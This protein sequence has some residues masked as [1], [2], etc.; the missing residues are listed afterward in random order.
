MELVSNTFAFPWEVDLMVWLQ[1]RLP[2]SLISLFSKLSFFGEEI[3]LIAVLGFL[4]WSYDKRSA[5]RIGAVLVMVN[6]WSPMIKNVI[7]RRRPYMAHEK[8]SIKR[9]VAADADLNDI[10]AQGYSFP[11]QHSANISG[12]SSSLASVFKKPWLTWLGAVLTLLVGV[13]RVIV[14]AHYPTDVLCGWALGLLI[15]VLVSALDRKIADK[16]VLYGILL[17][18]ALPGLFFCKSKDYFT[19]LGLM[20]GLFCG[21]LFEEKYVNFENTRNPVRAV[22]RVLGGGLLF[23]GLNTALKLPFP[24]D[25]LEGSS[26]AAMLVRCARYA[27]SA[28]TAFAIY[29]MLFKY[30]AKIGK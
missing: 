15:C 23:L 24:K 28:F 4:Y 3:F 11:S 8:I 19:G 9:A 27:V 30:T 17:L 1:S 6:V 16:R 26:Y 7:L 2:D 14:G 22:L 25:F 29:P 20:I 18:S 5:K 21:A 13:S 12:L 10:A